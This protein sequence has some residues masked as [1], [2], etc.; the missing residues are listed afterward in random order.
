MFMVEIAKA[1][2]TARYYDDIAVALGVPRSTLPS[3]FEI[4]PPKPTPPLEAAVGDVSLSDIEWSVIAQVFPKGV[5][6]HARDDRAYLNACLWRE[7][8]KPFKKGWWFVPVTFGPTSSNR[9]RFLRWCALG[10]WTKLHADLV[11]LGGLSE[12]RLAEFA[13]I[14]D[15]AKD[16]HKR[17]SDIRR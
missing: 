11:A 2:A 10:Y 3:G 13:A 12:P 14:A 15:E 16:R 6:H 1:E 7:R 17:P 5:A 9:G 8:A 4:E